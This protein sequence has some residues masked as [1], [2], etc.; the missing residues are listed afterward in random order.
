MSVKRDALDALFS[1]CIRAA[2]NTCEA[3]G[4]EYLNGGESLTHCHGDLQCCHIK[5]RRYG[6]LRCEPANAI[7]MCA[8]HH[9]WFT[10]NPASFGAF[11]EEIRPG[12]EDLL[13]E[14]LQ[15]RKHFQ[16]KKHKGE[17]R[18]HYRAELKRIVSER[19]DG[20]TGPLKVIGWQ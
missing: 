11:I 14:L 6:A 13:N 2:A 18:Q 9:R 8:R 17:M 7:S 20:H 16:L 12:T 1:D 15:E 19:V 3:M 4:V 10:D 5:T